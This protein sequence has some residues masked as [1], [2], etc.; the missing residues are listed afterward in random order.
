MKHINGQPTISI[1]IVMTF[2]TI[3]MN[4]IGFFH[5]A[6]THKN[7]ILIVVDYFTKWIKAKVL[8]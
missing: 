6:P 4:I 8:T 7:F 2:R 1:D 5:P 3:G